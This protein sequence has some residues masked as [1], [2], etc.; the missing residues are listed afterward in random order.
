MSRWYEKPAEDSDVVVSAAVS[1]SRNLDGIPFPARMSLSDRRRVWERIRAAAQRENSFFSGRLRAVGLESLSELQAASLAERGLISAELVSDREGRGLLVSEDESLSASVNGEDHLSIRA[2]AAGSDLEGAYGAADG[3]DTFF[4]RTFPWA[5]D[6]KL[7]YLTQNP[8]HLG[9]GMIVSL[10]LHLPALTESGSLAR[11]SQN[12]SRLGLSLY[13]VYGPESKPPGTFYLLANR[14]TLGISE[15]EAVANLLSMAGQILRQERAMRE[16]L[17][18]NLD[19]QDAVWRNLGI[20]RNARLLTFGEF[21]ERVGTVRLG[22]ASGLVHGV[23]ITV[24]DALA[25]R[26]RPATLALETGA[27]PPAEENRALRARLVRE[28]LTGGREDFD[29]HGKKG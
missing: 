27:P 24:L 5:F 13:G 4:D 7:G 10:R 29:E 15:R 26:I 28:A 22:I 25:V 6:E 17:L 16:T 1:L 11:V 23:G 14:V 12:L 3:L 18:A 2:Q 20:L 9:T 19:F 8:F 21:L